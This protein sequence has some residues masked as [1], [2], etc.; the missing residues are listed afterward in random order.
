MVNQAF[1]DDGDR[2]KAAV[3]VGREAGHL[4]SVVHVPAVLA[5]KVLTQ[6]TPGQR[7]IRSHLSIAAGVG[8]VV[9]NTKQ[10]RVDSRPGGISQGL[11]VEDGGHRHE[12]ISNKATPDCHPLG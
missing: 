2:L 9:V 8:I 1:A 5:S 7:S 12:G 4:F 11:Q 6:I 3:R 10:K